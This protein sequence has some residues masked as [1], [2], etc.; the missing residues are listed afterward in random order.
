MIATAFKRRSVLMVLARIRLSGALRPGAAALGHHWV[1][2][3][4]RSIH[5]L[6]GSWESGGVAGP[7]QGSTTAKQAP[8]LGACS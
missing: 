1:F 8:P 3:E 4:D 6:A 2:D 7:E 5:P